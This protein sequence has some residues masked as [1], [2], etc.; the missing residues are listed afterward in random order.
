MRPDDTTAESHAIQLEVYRRL[1]PTGRAELAA[2][3]S[4]DTRR[5]TRDGI[6][7]RHP[8]Y[9]EEDLDHA[10]WRLVYGDDLF[11][12]AWPRQPLLAP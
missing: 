6:R 5:I 2:R 1:G 4:D 9:S 3:L 11:R 12:R 8:E 10:V 7:A